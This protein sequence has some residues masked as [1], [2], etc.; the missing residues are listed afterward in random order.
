MVFCVQVFG[1]F[2]GTNLQVVME[3]AVEMATDPALLLRWQLTLH[4]LSCTAC[5]A[6]ELARTLFAAR[7]HLAVKVAPSTT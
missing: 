6:D 1:F 2:L 3:R 7:L 4:F 5:F